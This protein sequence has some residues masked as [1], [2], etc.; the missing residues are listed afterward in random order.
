MIGIS[1]VS[2]QKL[3]QGITSLY[4]EDVQ[5]ASREKHYVKIQMIAND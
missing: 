1:I 5:D 4:I 3:D 2:V